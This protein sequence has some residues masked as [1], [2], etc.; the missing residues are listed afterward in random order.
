MADGDGGAINWSNW[1]KRG[2][3]AGATLYGPKSGTIETKMPSSYD[4]DSG[5]I[6]LSGTGGGPM[7]ILSITPEVL[8]GD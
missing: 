1:P 7:Y 4:E 2:V 3:A 6:V 5:Q 8:L